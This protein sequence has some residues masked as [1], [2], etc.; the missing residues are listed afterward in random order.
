MSI[1]KEI[2]T[3]INFRITLSQRKYITF[4]EK[5]FK[6]NTSEV[7]RMLINVSAQEDKLNYK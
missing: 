2:T 6:M 5:K 3:T 4:L 1:N 7:L